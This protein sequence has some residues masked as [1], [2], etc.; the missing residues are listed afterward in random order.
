M[1]STPIDGTEADLTALDKRL[2]ATQSL[3]EVAILQHLV[4]TFQADVWKAT[5]AINRQRLE[6]GYCQ[7][8]QAK[9]GEET[10]FQRGSEA[11]WLNVR[12]SE[13]YASSP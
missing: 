11:P 8:Q 5:L 1:A 9:Q 13:V 6:Q 3:A 10:D 2:P 12:K 4:R 7:Q